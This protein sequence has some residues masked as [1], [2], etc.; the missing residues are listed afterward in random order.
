MPHIYRI[1]YLLCIVSSPLMSLPRTRSQAPTVISDK[2]TLLLQVVKKEIERL[3]RER[4]W[5]N[6]LRDTPSI[7]LTLHSDSRRLDCFDKNTVEQALEKLRALPSK[8]GTRHQCPLCTKSYLG[9]GEISR[10]ML[11]HH[12]PQNRPYPCPFCSEGFVRKN[13]FEQHMEQHE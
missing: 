5:R 8:K 13:R 12:E 7:E 1:L 2:Q 9:K 6:L 11:Y 3:E 4:D 10:H